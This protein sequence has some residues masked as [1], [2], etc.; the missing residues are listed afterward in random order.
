MRMFAQR[1]SGVLGGLCLYEKFRRNS[2]VLG[3]LCLYDNFR[4][5]KQRF[6]GLCLYKNFRTEK[7]GFGRLCLYEN[8]RT[9][10]QRG[11]G[12]TVRN[13]RPDW[14]G[15]KCSFDLFNAWLELGL[16]SEPMML[17]M[18][19][20]EEACE[21]L[22]CSASWAQPLKVNAATWTPWQALGA[23][24]ATGGL[25]MGHCILAHLKVKRKA[26]NCA[27][28]A[29]ASLRSVLAVTNQWSLHP[30]G[31]G[32]HLSVFA[33]FQPT[34]SISSKGARRCLLHKHLVL[35]SKLG[36]VEQAKG[37]ELGPLC[38]APAIIAGIQY[39]AFQERTAVCV[40]PSS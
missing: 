40:A 25:D 6:R 23:C 1:S 8:F 24:A 31:S 4:T 5:E 30:T 22:A 33:F 21:M 28:R 38:T 20:S 37:G 9:E 14:A 2:V 18:L 13:S 36:K 16:F 35:R 7:R 10:K 15:F 32:K 27:R 3:E 29:S 26:Q 39:Q 19:L 11:F 17:V 12:E 34:A